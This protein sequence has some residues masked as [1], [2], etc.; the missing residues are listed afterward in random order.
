MIYILHGIHFYV[1]QTKEESSASVDLIRK[2]IKLL[3]CT[4]LGR[5][6]LIE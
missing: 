3:D 6:K 4:E 2:L 1:I 5:I